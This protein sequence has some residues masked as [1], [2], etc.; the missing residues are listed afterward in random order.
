MPTGR[1]D[2]AARLF[3]MTAMSAVAEGHVANTVWK[4]LAWPACEGEELPP[5]RR[6]SCRSA[7]TASRMLEAKDD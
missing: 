4:A 1:H 2:M 6:R 5:P 3:L 7:A